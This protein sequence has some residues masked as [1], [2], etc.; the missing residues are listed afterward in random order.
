MRIPYPFG[1]RRPLHFPAVLA[2]LL[3]FVAAS[4]HAPVAARGDD[5]VE[6]PAAR[7]A[8]GKQAAGNSFLWKATSKGGKT[9]YLLGSIHVGREDFYPLPPE[10]ERAFDDS[11]V[12][13]VEVDVQKV[14]AGAVQQ[15]MLAKGMYQGGGSLATELSDDTL[16]AFRDYCRKKNL[17]AQALEMFRPWAVAI[18]LA[19]MELQSL[20]YKPDLGIDHHFLTKAHDGKKRVVELET[21]ESQIDLLSGFGKE[22]EEKFLVQTLA[23][24]DDLPQT[25]EK[26]AA[27]WK[28]GDV[29]TL[30]EELLEKSLREAP[31]TKPVFEKLFDE[32]NEKMAEQVEG[33]LKGDE[34]Y[35]VV[36][37]AGHLVGEKGIVKLLE[38]KGYKLQQVRVSAA[39][40]TRRKK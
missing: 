24:M 8:K 34:Q 32:R 28:A 14:N 39:G 37:G 12:L 4:V 40:G 35:F 2:V 10:I 21:A 26:A 23:G 7:Q 17:P 20:G 13:A 1:W 30:Q 22:M 29:D 11:D 3:A 5:E 31:E 6:R 9:A 16:K 27:A 18:T 25:M 36:V 19:M 33:F 15:A 38:G